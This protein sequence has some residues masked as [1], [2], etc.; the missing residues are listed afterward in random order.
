MR[1]FY[2]RTCWPFICDSS[3]K[4]THCHPE[5]T[6]GNSAPAAT[7]RFRPYG[8][9]SWTP[10]RQKHNL[11]PLY[12]SNS[13]SLCMDPFVTVILIGLPAEVPCQRHGWPESLKLL[14]ALKS[15]WQCLC[16]KF[17][18]FDRYLAWHSQWRVSSTLHRLAGIAAACHPAPDAG[19]QG[20]AAGEIAVPCMPKSCQ[21]FDGSLLLPAAPGNAADAS[22]LLIPSDLPSRR[23]RYGEV[24][25][26]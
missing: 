7:P 6:L 22:M 26:F 2:E 9:L 18:S 1:S 23:V 12:A 8:I 11:W 17:T 3:H 4:T 19:R 14:M 24:Q 21:G 20:P 25:K 13:A 10:A 5:A 15:E 16:R